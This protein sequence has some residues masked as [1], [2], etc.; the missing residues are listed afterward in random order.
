MLRIILVEIVF[1]V[2][3]EVGAPAVVFNTKLLRQCFKF[4]GVSGDAVTVSALLADR[5]KH[6]SAAAVF[7]FNFFC[8]RDFKTK[9]EYFDC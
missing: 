3:F 5:I 2:A 9:F 4:N 7:E 6:P 8:I 1:V